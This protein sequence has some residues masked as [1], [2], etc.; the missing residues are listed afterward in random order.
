MRFFEINEWML[1]WQKEG[2]F[3]QNISGSKKEEYQKMLAPKIVLPI[4]S[5]YKKIIF[6]NPSQFLTQ[7]NNLESLN[8]ATCVTSISK[9]YPNLA[10]DTF[11]PLFFLDQILSANFFQKFP[12]FFGGKNWHESGYFDTL[13]SSLSLIKVVPRGL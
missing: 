2:S 7:Q 4:K 13:P 5:L 1:C 8:W 10:R 3:L 12:N 11:I 6:K 9:E